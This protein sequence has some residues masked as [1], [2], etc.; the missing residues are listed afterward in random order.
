MLMLPQ[1]K[2]PKY[3]LFHEA[4]QMLHMMWSSTADLSPV[5]SL[6]ISESLMLISGSVLCR[7]FEFLVE[8]W[9]EQT[10][11]NVHLRSCLPFWITNPLAL[12]DKQMCAC[13]NH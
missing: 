10:N 3:Q 6:A 7:V 1:I 13:Q 8:C 11:S 2:S 5:S 12:T 4:I 9:V